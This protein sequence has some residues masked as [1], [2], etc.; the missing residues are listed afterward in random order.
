M[1]SKIEQNINTLVDTNLNEYGLGKKP[2]PAPE[3]TYQTK[4]VQG[5]LLA[6]RMPV[7]L[8]KLDERRAERER[9]QENME[10]AQG[11]IDRME[12]KLAVRAD[13]LRRIARKA[14]DEFVWDTPKGSS[15]TYVNRVEFD[16]LSQCIAKFIGVVMETSCLEWK[17]GHEWSLERGALV[18][19]IADHIIENAVHRGVYGKRT[20]EV[21]NDAN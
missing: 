11:R 16:E 18:S 7:A 3:P 1:T 10:T 6:G 21:K 4:R 9:K 19:L 8:K 12:T 20:I 13:E 15:K 17:S 2:T 5:D 14:Q